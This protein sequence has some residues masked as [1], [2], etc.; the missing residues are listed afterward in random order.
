VLLLVALIDPEVV[1]EEAG[2]VMPDP[3]VIVSVA[4]YIL[5]GNENVAFDPL[6]EFPLISSVPLS[7]NV[8]GPTH[9]SLPFWRF[10]KSW[11]GQRLSP[12][13]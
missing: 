7:A 3:G 2:L 10:E 1:K 8:P 11:L 4:M 5:T 6:D 9:H 13:L 12:Q